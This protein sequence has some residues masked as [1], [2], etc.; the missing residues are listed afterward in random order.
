MWEAFS[1]EAT[2][3]GTHNST[4]NINITYSKSVSNNQ[5][6]QWAMFVVKGVLSLKNSLCSSGDT[7]G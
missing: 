3:P 2:L 6:V 1:Q 5:F 4:N 7:S